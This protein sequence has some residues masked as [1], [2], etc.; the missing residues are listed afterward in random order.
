VL[1]GTDDKVVKY[2]RLAIVKSFVLQTQSLS[3][4]AAEHS[5]SY[6]LLEVTNAFF[7]LGFG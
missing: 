5:V 6:T 4:D 2:E 1:L 3:V 7:D